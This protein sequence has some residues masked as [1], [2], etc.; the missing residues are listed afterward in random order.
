MAT[1]PPSPALFLTDDHTSSSMDCPQGGVWVT[2]EW[3]H[4]VGTYNAADRRIR[5]RYALARTVL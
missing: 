2:T 3:T 1:E 5:S 4:P